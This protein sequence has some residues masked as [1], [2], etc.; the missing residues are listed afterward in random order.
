MQIKM[1]LEQALMR[2]KVRAATLDQYPLIK[3]LLE[4]NHI[5]AESTTRLFFSTDALP[6][7]VQNSIRAAGGTISPDIEY[8]LE[9][10]SGDSV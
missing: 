2:F 3:Q 5:H 4:G 1:Y 8:E 7:S 6:E 10:A 9:D